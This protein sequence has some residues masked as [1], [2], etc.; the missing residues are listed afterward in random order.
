[1]LRAPVD[2]V[3]LAA[4]VDFG[5]VEAAADLS[6]RDV[7]GAPIPDAPSAVAIARRSDG[8]ADVHPID[9]AVAAALMSL[10]D[11]GPLD[12]DPDTIDDLWERQL[13]RAARWTVEP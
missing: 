13:I 5:D 4:A 6:V 9:L 2:V 1:V 10:G 12:L 7:D 8:D 11:G 3:Q